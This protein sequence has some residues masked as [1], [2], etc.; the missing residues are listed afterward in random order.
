MSK[1]RQFSLLS[2]SLAFLFILG[3]Y[4]DPYGSHLL[5]LTS[6]FLLL[7]GSFLLFI[8][9]PGWQLGG[10][11]EALFLPVS[12]L[13]AF[14]LFYSL[15]PTHWWSQ[16]LL[17][18]LVSL[19][20][21]FAIAAGNIFF[22]ASRFRIVP[23]YRAALSLSFL[24]ILG[25]LYLLFDF[26]FS[27]RLTFWQNGFLAML[28]SAPFFLYLFRAAAIE[29][30]TISWWQLAPFVL[31]ASIITGELALALSFLPLT[32]NFFTLYLL[33]FVYLL[34][35]LLQAALQQ[36]LS[37]FTLREYLAVGAG[38]LMALIFLG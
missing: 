32:I 2:L 5:I 24:F 23:L 17:F 25:E 29:E 10:I 4:F 22:V 35:G 36:R 34:G 30:R 21:Y 18:F 14:Q 28:L 8:L 33:S 19:G 38:I 37:R 26:L 27:F 20:V 16:L 11:F 3:R 13:T 1:Q 31:A 12:F 6:V 9:R 7:A 15:L